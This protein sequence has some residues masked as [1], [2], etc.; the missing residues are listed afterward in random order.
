MQSIVFP[1]GR[2][3][4][5]LGQ[6]TWHMGDNSLRRK[7]EIRALQ[8]GI[9]LGLTAIDTAEMYGN[10]KSEQLVG[11]AIAGRR[12]AVFLI[13]K[14]LPSHAS[15]QGTKTAC[16]ASLR[17]L[18][19]DVIDLYLLHWSGSYPF[20]DTLS[21]MLDLQ[22]EGKIRYWGL[23][24]MDVVELEA[25]YAL[26]KGN[27]CATNQVLYNL[28][29][30]GIEYDLLP[31]CAARSL[32]VMAYSPLEQGRILQNP[33]VMAVALRHE[34]PPAAVALAWTLRRP[35]ILSIPKSGSEQ[36][37]RANAQALSLTLTDE[38]I[39][40]LNRAFPAPTCKRPLELL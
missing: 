2:T 35:G 19:V 14:V 7:D 20:A 28:S 24:N 4:C 39:A 36:H 37:V 22:A 29:R 8:V 25:F 32:P 12:D 6:G 13:S 27:T 23:S 33:A 26:K 15:R 31:W 16:E 3:V 38:D 40:E 9:D 30:R 18:N 5:A 17:R 34:A 21:G 11:E 1:G 10:G